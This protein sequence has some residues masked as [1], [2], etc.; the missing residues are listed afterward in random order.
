[1][2]PQWLESVH[3]DGS[4]DYVS[5]LHPALGQTVAVRVSFYDTAPVDH[6]LLR[7]IPNGAEVLTEARLLEKRMTPAAGH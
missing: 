3:S 7:S 4:A 6:V 2:E 5:C 1:M